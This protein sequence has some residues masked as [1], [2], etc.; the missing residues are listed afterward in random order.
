M[1]KKTKKLPW[2]SDL[3]EIEKRMLAAGLMQGATIWP[4]DLMKIKRASKVSANPK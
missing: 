3:Q 1:K 4:K 2:T